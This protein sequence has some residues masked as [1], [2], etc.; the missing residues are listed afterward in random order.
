MGPRFSSYSVRQWSLKLREL[1]PRRFL[2][3]NEP[4]PD[5]HASP[6]GFPG[7]TPDMERRLSYELTAKG[8]QQLDAQILRRGH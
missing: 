3:R 7:N 8:T 2:G 1:L 5:R 4:A 6:S